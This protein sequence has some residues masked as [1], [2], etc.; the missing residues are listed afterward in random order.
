LEYVTADVFLPASGLVYE[1]RFPQ[2]INVQIAAMLTAKSLSELS[3]GNYLSS[4][5]SCLA[6]RKDGKLLDMSK[7]MHEC[8]VRNSSELILI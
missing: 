1:V 8:G 5:A 4:K 3:E 6:W 2:D 7:T